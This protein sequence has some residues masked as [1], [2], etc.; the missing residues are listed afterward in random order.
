MNKE[1]KDAKRYVQN[2]F[3]EY[4]PQNYE[5]VMKGDVCPVCGSEDTDTIAF[6]EH[7]FA[8]FDCDKGHEWRVIEGKLEIVKGEIK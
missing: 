3:R 4:Q 8:A 2:Y 6:S 5:L 1:E 7:G